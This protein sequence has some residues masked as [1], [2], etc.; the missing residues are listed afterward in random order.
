MCGGLRLGVCACARV[1]LGGTLRARK[2]HNLIKWLG[3]VPARPADAPFPSW[4]GPVL[5]VT[6]RWRV[7]GAG[8]EHVVLAAWALT[9]APVCWPGSASRPEPSRRT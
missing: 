5:V 3:V 8:S 9:A 6:R 4:V 1:R 2:V 7:A